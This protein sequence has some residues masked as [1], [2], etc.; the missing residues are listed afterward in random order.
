MLP[1][2]DQQQGQAGGQ[3]SFN[4]RCWVVAAHLHGSCSKFLA[5]HRPCAT[6]RLSGGN[7]RG[8]ACAQMMG[9]VE[10]SELR[11]ALVGLP[12]LN[13]LSVEQRK[14]LSIAV[15]L[16]ANPAIVFMD[17]PTLV[18]S[19]VPAAGSCT[20]LHESPGA[21]GTAAVHEPYAQN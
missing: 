18:I 21:A 9:L 17:E 16:V 14:R 11:N 2:F 19:P 10:L 20:H 12:G 8:D 5:V 1:L 4:N 7:N 3:S 13:G 6:S 15:E